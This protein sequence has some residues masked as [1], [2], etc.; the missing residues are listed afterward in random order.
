MQI[1]SKHTM[2]SGLTQWGRF[3]YDSNTTVA[4]E[5]FKNFSFSLNLY[6]NF[7]NRP[8][9]EI[10]GKTDYGTVIGLSYKF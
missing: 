4:W 6:L 1:F 2:Y 7:D 3:R 9:D 5:L 8:P 10:S